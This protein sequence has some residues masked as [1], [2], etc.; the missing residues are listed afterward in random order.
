[1]LAS[2]HTEALTYRVPLAGDVAEGVSLGARATRMENN[3]ERTTERP[4]RGKRGR[5]VDARAL[6]FSHVGG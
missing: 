2:A 3:R 4:R 6:R 5:P 1:M